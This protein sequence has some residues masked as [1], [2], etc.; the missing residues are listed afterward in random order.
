MPGDAA[1]YIGNI[2][3]S[4]YWDVEYLDHKKKE[5]VQ[6]KAHICRICQ[7]NRAFYTTKVACNL[8]DLD[9]QWMKSLNQSLGQAPRGIKRLLVKGS[10][11]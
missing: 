5:Q 7:D 8:F 1:G 2:T 3:D 9:Q 10:I 4:D 6:Y 11:L